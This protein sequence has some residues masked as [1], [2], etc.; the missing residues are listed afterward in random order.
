M[1]PTATT[2]SI[3]GWEIWNSAASLQGFIVSTPRYIAIANPD[4]KRW[5]TFAHDLAEFW[6]ERG[7]EPEVVVVPWRDVVPR[8]GN[9]DDLHAFDTPAIVRLESPGR[10]FEVTRLL[11]EAGE[12]SDR[13][14]RSGSPGGFAGRVSSRDVASPWRNLT[15]NKGQVVRPG[16]LHRGFCRVL[17]GLRS[18]FNARPHLR[19]LACPL[20]VAEMFDK[21][22][23]AARLE[24]AGLPCPPCWSP[25]FLAVHS[26]P[27][28]PALGEQGSRETLVGGGEGSGVRGL[29]DN[30]AAPLTPSPSPP[31]DR[32]SASDDSTGRGERGAVT[33]LL[34]GLRRRQWKTAY[35]KL[36]TGSS[37]SGIAVVHACDEP[38]WA[39]TSL[40]HRDGEFFN[41]RR[42]QLVRGGELDAVLAF[43]LREDAMVQQ[44]IPMAQIDGQNFDVRVVMI[45]GRPAFTVFRLSHQPMTNLHL[46]GRRGDLA[47]CRAAI[48]TRAWLD[49]LDDCTAAARLYPTCAAIGI[50]VVF[51]RGYLRHYLL[52]V[53]AFGDFFPGL[54]DE[55]GRSV[56]RVEIEETAQRFASDMNRS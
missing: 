14:A 5:Q 16:L 9:F 36:N 33:A 45:H 31:A 42:L 43:I 21:R 27:L 44:G 32:V 28:S 18:A 41:T 37:A 10:D 34:E 40:L 22:A 23:T 46:G 55:R 39:I 30:R 38:P 56:H 35:V 6:A 26:S 52:E 54:Q 1:L 12:R 8:D 15:H 53:N 47:A 20:A 4:S 29:Q 48:P 50:D 51:E 3:C 25:L 7:V 49:V 11:L 24:A 13:Q 17:Q 19:P 2:W